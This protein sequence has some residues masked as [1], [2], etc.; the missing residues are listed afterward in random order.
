[1]KFLKTLQDYVKFEYELNTMF[2]AAVPDFQSWAMENWGLTYYK[3]QCL[4][5][6]ENPHP[7]EIFDSMRIMSNVIGHQFFGNVATMK[8][9]DQMWLN[10]GMSALFE[11][12]LVELV[13]PE[14]R[15]FDM[16]NLQKLQNGFKIDVESAHPMNFEGNYIY[17]IFYDKSE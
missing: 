10:E 1:M 6:D 7:R 3:E 15:A 14:A 11:Y 4:I 17:G 5:L 13:Y 12:R 8:W 2:S 9:W 16:F